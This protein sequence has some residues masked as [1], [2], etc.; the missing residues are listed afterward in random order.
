MHYT[1]NST[2]LKQERCSSTE[3]RTLKSATQQTMPQVILL[4]SK[5]RL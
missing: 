3:S 2:N 1:D 5:K 4:G